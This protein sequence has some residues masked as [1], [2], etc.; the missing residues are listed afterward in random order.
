M[1]NHIVSETMVREV[2]GE[3]D[4]LFRLSDKNPWINPLDTITLPLTKID[5]RQVMH[6]VL[7]Y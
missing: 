1:A 2:D 5:Q 3:K 7:N 4:K 6:K